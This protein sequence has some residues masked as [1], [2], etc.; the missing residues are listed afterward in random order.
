M[1]PEMA[2]RAARELAELG[3]KLDFLMFLVGGLY[4][5]VFAA[6]MVIARLMVKAARG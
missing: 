4:V 3:A 1:S 5:A 6:S 2:N